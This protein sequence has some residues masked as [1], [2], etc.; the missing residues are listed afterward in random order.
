MDPLSLVASIITVVGVGGKATKAIRKLAL[1]K[2]APEIVLALNNEITDLNLTMLAIQDIL[3]KHQSDTPTS[4]DQNWQVKMY[5]NVSSSLSQTKDKV[6]R[7]ELLHDRLERIMSE[8]KTSK[9][10][11]WLCEQTELK[12]VQEDL[13][14][15]RQKLISVL[16]MLNA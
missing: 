5:Q 12:S 16:G 15:A 4:G 3:Q 9:K 1:V 7:L 10:I 8:P 11:A 14:S 2:D 6:T 13:R